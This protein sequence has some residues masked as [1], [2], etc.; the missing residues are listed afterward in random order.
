MP[1]SGPPINLNDQKAL[2]CP[3][4]G[5]VYM[6]WYMMSNTEKSAKLEGSLIGEER[7]RYWDEQNKFYATDES[8]EKTVSDDD[9]TATKP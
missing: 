3:H 7:Q 4:E 5:D 8:D 1:N 6:L 9:E 2:P